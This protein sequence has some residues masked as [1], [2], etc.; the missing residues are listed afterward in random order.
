MF[1]QKCGAAYEGNKCP[2]G[3]NA[4]TENKKK[5]KSIFKKWWFWVI[6]A[7]VV[8]AVASGGG[9]ESSTTNDP[10]STNAANN[11]T[12]QPA[13]TTEATQ[14]P[15]NT[16]APG[17]VINANGLEI[18]YVKAEKHIED[19]MF[20]Q[21][22]EGYMYIRLFLSVDNKSD[23]DKFI[24]S[25]EFTCYA[26]GKKAESYYSSTEALEGGTLSA[27]RKDEGYIY[28]KVPTTAQEIEVEYETS[29]WTD[30]KAILVV[31]LNG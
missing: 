24:S 22:E 25:F 21:P 17:D 8:I 7:I 11:T 3:C 27:G 16:Y 28:F 13:T 20:L 14:P 15:S 31:D 26:D 23:S 9:E 2:N 30:K 5:K 12:P 4:E 1:C 19:N 10:V 6:V 29:F 18:T